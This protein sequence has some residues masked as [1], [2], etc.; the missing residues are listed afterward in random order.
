MRVSQS[1]GQ[2]WNA[3]HESRAKP[4]YRSRHV[5]GVAMECDY[6]GHTIPI[7]DPSTGEIRSADLCGGA[8][9]VTTD[10]LL[11][12]LQPKAARLNRG[13]PTGFQLLRWRDE[14]HDLRQPQVCSGQ[15]SLVPTLNAT[16]A[17]FADH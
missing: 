6:A 8:E 1:S 16:F 2:R 12:Q 14:D 5:G 17:A 10:V 9:R 7:I 4:T 15:G 3:D 11:C 13:E